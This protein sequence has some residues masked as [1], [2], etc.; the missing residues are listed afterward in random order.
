[1]RTRKRIVVVFAQHSLYHS[2]FRPRRKKRLISRQWNPKHYISLEQ[3]RV[4]SRN[5]LEFRRPPGGL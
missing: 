5:E 3:E 1:M 4:N 2:F